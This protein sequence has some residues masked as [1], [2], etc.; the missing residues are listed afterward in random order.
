[1]SPNK[2]NSRLSWNTLNVGIYQRQSIREKNPK[3]ILPKTKSLT[4]LHKFVSPSNTSMIEKFSTGTLRAK[5]FSSQ[6]QIH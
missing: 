3:N 6:K 2:T 4:G 1:M 5:I